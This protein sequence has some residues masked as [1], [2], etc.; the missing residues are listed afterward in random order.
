MLTATDLDAVAERL[1]AGKGEDAA[2]DDLRAVLAGEEDG[3]EVSLLK[4][5]IDLV[6]ESSPGNLGEMRRRGLL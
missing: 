3:W 5:A 1:L 4:L 6:G 2:N